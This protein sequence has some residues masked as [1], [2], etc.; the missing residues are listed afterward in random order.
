[1]F[2]PTAT[3]DSTEPMPFDR[4]AD[5]N[6]ARVSDDTWRPIDWDGLERCLATGLV[7]IGSHSHLHLNGMECGS[8][9]LVEEASVSREILVRRLGKDA[10][11]SYAYPYGCTRLGQIPASYVAAVQAAGYELAV[12]TDLGIADAD[13]NL[14][15]LPRIEAHPVDGR[16]AICAK[17]AG[18]IRPYYV[19]DWLRRVR[20][21]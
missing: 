14:H 8:D 10:A 2:V 17:A 21:A 5:K 12:S 6:R 4:W 20:R 13:S 11:R 18:S 7:S 9:Q 1:L 19:T 3:I 16:G 15:A